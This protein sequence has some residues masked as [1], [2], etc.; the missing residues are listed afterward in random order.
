MATSNPS[1]YMT[2]MHAWANARQLGRFIYQQTARSAAA[3]VLFSGLTVEVTIKAYLDGGFSI[4][5]PTRISILSWIGLYKNKGEISAFRR[6]KGGDV[7][8][9]GTSNRLCYPR[10]CK[11]RVRLVVV[12]EPHAYW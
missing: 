7:Q 1:I 4:E 2:R 3:A 10:L 11:M 8:Y 5:K 6:R 12:I 9:H